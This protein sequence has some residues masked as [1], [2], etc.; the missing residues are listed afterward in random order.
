MVRRHLENDSE[1]AARP[2]CLLDFRGEEFGNMM[3]GLPVISGVDKLAD[4]IKKYSVECVILA[5]ST[6]PT[7]VRK[8]VRE[9][10]GEMNVEVQDFAGFF[11]ES[12]GAVT[13][14]NLMEYAKGEVE[15]VVN[16]KSQ[17]FANGEQAVMSVTGKYVVKS[18][19]AH[20][21]RLVV[22]LQKDI[23]VPNDVKEKWVQTYEKET[24]ED[25]SFF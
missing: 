11:Q 7:D 4:A 22:E 18:V 8:A 15:L 17:S 12:R 21:N 9:I 16:G 14:R 2:V 3:E 1:N 5:D 13:L 23:L 10:C 20:E 6:M 24:G 25:I 19:A